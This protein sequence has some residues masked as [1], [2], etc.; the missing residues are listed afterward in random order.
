MSKATNKAEIANKNLNRA[1]VIGLQI[2]IQLLNAGYKVTV[3]AKHLPGDLAVEYTSPWAGAHWR[4]HA[5]HDDKE[6]QKWDRETYDYWLSLLA[7]ELNEPEGTVAKSGLGIYDSVFYS[8]NDE[9]PWFHKDVLR[10]KEL[11]VEKVP[12]GMKHGHRYSSIMINTPM[13][14]KFLM[15]DAL[16]QGATVIGAA[17]P[18]S[19]S[20]Q[21][22]LKAAGDIVN[23]HFRQMS[24]FGEYKS[25]PI[26]AFVNATGIGA[27]TFAND[28][29]IF[30]ISGQTV[31]VRG[32]ASKITTVDADPTSSS[33]SSISYALPRPH[34]D[35]TILGG[36]KGVNNWSGEPDPQVT[37]R[38]LEDAKKWAPELL[39]EKG[40]FD[41]VSAQV[42]LRP[43]RKGGARVEIETF[44]DG[45]VCCHAYGNAGA[46]YQNSVGV[47]SKV[48]RLFKEHFEQRSEKAESGESKL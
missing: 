20:T 27:R 41:V 21:Y 36:T 44:A 35:V 4:S 34:S 43:G 13:Y 10:Y 30:P 29:A 7:R 1:G 37:K 28:N 25:I 9:A 2:A 15:N 5:S 24:A 33:V 18:T 42:G 11:P 19:T 47:A 16:S 26:T 3:L 39:N 40:E 12:E 31:T 32:S 45:M 46:G 38:I 48:V 8:S 6:Q 14:L 22:S 17:V 23:A